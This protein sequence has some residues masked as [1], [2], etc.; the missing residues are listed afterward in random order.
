MI[1]YSL[2]LYLDL[3]HEIVVSPHVVEKKLLMLSKGYN[4][5]GTSNRKKKQTL[6]NQQQSLTCPQGR[7]LH[8]TPYKFVF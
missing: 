8:P 2:L 1:M 5:L 6:S 3:Y 7:C 4:N